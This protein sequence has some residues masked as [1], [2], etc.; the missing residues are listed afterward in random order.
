MSKKLNLSPWHD[1]SVKP[2]HVGV[3]EVKTKGCIWPED[4]W[5]SFWNGIRFGWVDCGGVAGAYDSRDCF[6]SIR[7]EDYLQWRGVLK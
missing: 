4:T 3:Y 5:Y 7:V 2:V 1:G 6:T